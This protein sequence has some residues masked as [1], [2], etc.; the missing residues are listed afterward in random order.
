MSNLLL[1][2]S[3]FMFLSTFFIYQLIKRKENNNDNTLKSP[4]EGS[5][6]DGL[7]LI[8]ESPILKQICLF[9]LLYTTISTFLYF[10][11]AHIISKV[12]SSGLRSGA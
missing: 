6:W 9:I 2:S 1:V 12:Y 3:L 8:L 10:E 4:M 7:K 5:M 11:Q